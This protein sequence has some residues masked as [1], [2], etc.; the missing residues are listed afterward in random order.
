MP[1]ETTF[2]PPSPVEPHLQLV[3]SVIWKGRRIR[4]LW[5]SLYFRPEKETFHEFLIYVVLWTLGEQWWKHQIRMPVE[6]RHVV[7]RWRYNFSEFTKKNVGKPTDTS[8]SERFTGDTSGTIHALLALGYDL[9]C[10]QTKNALPEFLIKKLRSNQDFQGARYEVTVAAIMTRAG[11]EITYLDDKGI[12]QKHCE[13]IAKHKETG[14]EIGVEAKSRV[15]PGV[16]NTKGEFD[17]HE[18]WKGVGQ[19]VRKARKQKPPAL[20]FFI[21]VDVNLP[22]S[23]NDPPDKK[24]WLRDMIAAFDKSYEAPTAQNPDPFNA[25]FPTNFAYYYGEDPAE[26]VYGEWG[27]I[28]PRFSETLLPD[29][30][31]IDTTIESLERY[32]KVPEEV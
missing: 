22:P 13:F 21:F 16:L 7:T 32:G 6:E 19:L 28:I 30:R 1:E 24:P 20:P 23:P 14:I 3:P 25:L 12:Q 26:P 5:N 18:D 15:R 9:F 31:P 10:L 11:F 4:A 29:S 27:F 17:Y 8:S 2:S